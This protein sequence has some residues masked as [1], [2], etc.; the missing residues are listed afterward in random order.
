MTPRARSRSDPC[1]VGQISPEREISGRTTNEPSIRIRKPGLF[2]PILQK[3][4]QIVGNTLPKVISPRAHTFS[5][6]GKAALFGIAAAFFWRRNKRAALA[7]LVC[8]AAE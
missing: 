5:H 2:M 7:S 3:S 4:I 8:G 6:Y 1:Q